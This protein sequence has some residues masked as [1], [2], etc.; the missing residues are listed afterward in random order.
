[1]T[2]NELIAKLLAY[3]PNAK[4]KLCW[5]QIME[6]MTLE[7]EIPDGDDEIIMES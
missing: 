7:I 3:P 6:T 5:D 2:V 4:V 1:M